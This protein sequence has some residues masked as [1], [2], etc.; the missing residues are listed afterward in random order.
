MFLL[1]TQVWNGNK[2]LFAPATGLSFKKR[3]W[4]PKVDRKNIVI[5]AGR[6]DTTVPLYELAKLQE[7]SLDNI[8]FLVMKD[9]HGLYK[10]MIEEDQLRILIKV[11]S[12]SAKT[13]Y[14]L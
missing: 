1:Q 12:Q 3:I 7:S 2:I 8:E 9:D 6:G 13:I 14:S 4:L 11:N 5:V 10:S